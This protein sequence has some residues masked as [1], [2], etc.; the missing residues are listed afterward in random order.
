M[1]FGVAG[2]HAGRGVSRSRPAAAPPPARP[3]STPHPL[4]PQTPQVVNSIVKPERL[5]R[6][7]LILAGDD[8]NK[9]KPDPGGFIWGGG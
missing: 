5:K 1:T 9:K 2:C 4:T 7:D 8:V 3:S 6:F